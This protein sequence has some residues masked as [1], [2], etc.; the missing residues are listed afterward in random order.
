MARISKAQ[1]I[2]LQ[3][4]Y[5]TD[6]KIGEVFKISRQAVHQLRQKYGVASSI[7]DN[8]ERNAKLIK[9][10]KAGA[11]GTSLAKKFEMSMSQT[12][13]IINDANAIRKQPKKKKK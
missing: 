7:A 6:A 3:K 12:Y 8:P 10:Y 9:L 5:V 11:S 4:Q 1:L 13:R 2:K